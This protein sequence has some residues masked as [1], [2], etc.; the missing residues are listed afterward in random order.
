[1]LGSK[2]RTGCAR[3]TCEGRGLSLPLRVSLARSVFLVPITSKRLLCRLRLNRSLWPPPFLSFF[4]S[5]AP[6]CD[7]T[8]ALPNKSTSFCILFK[9]IKWLKRFKWK[10]QFSEWCTYIL[11]CDRTCMCKKRDKKKKHWNWYKFNVTKSDLKLICYQK[12]KIQTKCQRLNRS[13]KSKDIIYLLNH[14]IVRSGTPQEL[15]A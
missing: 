13:L 1:M 6:Q 11:K 10:I 15:S 5:G 2:E 4:V 3:K 7:Y 14:D 9:N 12:Y 8:V